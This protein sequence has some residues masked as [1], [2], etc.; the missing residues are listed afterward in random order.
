MEVD[1]STCPK[2]EGTVSVYR[3]FA[4][5]WGGNEYYVRYLHCNSCNQWYEETLVDIF[6]GP[7]K[8]TVEPI[9]KVDMQRQLVEHS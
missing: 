6:C 1:T 2:C 8:L 7:D 9:S 4:D 3:G 5:E